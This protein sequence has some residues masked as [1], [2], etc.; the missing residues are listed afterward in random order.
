MK[1]K[2]KPFTQ[3]TLDDLTIP[4]DHITA[5]TEQVSL[6]MPPERKS[7]RILQGE[8]AQQA[9]QLVHLLRTEAKLI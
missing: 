1:A 8:L 9:A 4:F 6:S 5:R 2:K 3:L 7:G